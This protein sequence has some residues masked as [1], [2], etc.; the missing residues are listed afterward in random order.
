MNEVLLFL[1]E[2]W[3]A[4]VAII[5]IPFLGF[6]IGVIKIVLVKILKTTLSVILSEKILIKLIL[7]LMGKLVKST[8]NKLDDKIYEEVKKK[9]ES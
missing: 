4:V 7:E 5:L 1:K 2:W 8:K 9:L 6:N 3:M